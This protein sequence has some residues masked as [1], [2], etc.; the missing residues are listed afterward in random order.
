MPKQ[1][2]NPNLKWMTRGYPQKTSKHVVL[3]GVSK[4]L[5]PR[6]RRYLSLIIVVLFTIPEIY[7]RRLAVEMRELLVYQG[8]DSLTAIY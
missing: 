4:H 3:F 8:V 6:V 7:S 2:Q 5:E 1:M